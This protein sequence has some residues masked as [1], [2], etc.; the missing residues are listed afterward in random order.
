MNKND[1]KH[2]YDHS[3]RDNSGNEH[4]IEGDVDGKDDAVI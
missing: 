1:K 2:A 4:D 3:S